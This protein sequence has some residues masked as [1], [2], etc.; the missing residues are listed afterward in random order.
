MRLVFYAGQ[1]F[2]E[3]PKRDYEWGTNGE[4]ICH[5]PGMRDAGQI[6]VVEIEDA[7]EP[8]VLQVIP[9]EPTEQEAREED[10]DHETW[11]TVDPPRCAGC[12]KVG[13]PMRQHNDT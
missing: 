8:T 2:S 6:R 3:G 9:Y 10:C 13:T 4:L 7:S 1:L 5:H 11:L 12:G